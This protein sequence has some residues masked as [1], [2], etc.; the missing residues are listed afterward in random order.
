MPVTW[1]S[2]ETASNSR[3]TFCLH[4]AIYSGARVRVSCILKTLHCNASDGTVVINVERG[5]YKFFSWWNEVGP[6]RSTSTPGRT[7]RYRKSIFLNT[8]E[9]MHLKFVI[10]G[11][12]GDLSPYRTLSRCDWNCQGVDQ[13]A[14]CRRMVAG[15]LLSLVWG[16]VKFPTVAAFHF[17]CDFAAIFWLFI[18][19]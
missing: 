11:R 5:L 19:F 9:R 4:M 7:E 16:A 8:F 6:G 15:S 10:D 13:I 17:C 2:A 3:D 18:Y 12:V 1:H 14:E